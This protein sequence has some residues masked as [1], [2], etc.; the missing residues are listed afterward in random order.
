VGGIFW[1]HP[2]P[3]GTVLGPL[4]FLA[5]INDLP[6]TVQHSSAWLFADNSL[7]RIKDQHDQALIQED[8][9]IL[10]EWEH[11]AN[12][13]Q[14]KQMQCHQC[15]KQTKVQTSSYLLHDQTLETT[16][17]WTSPS[18]VTPLLVHPCW[19]CSSKKKPDSGV[20]VKEHQ[21]MYPKSQVSDI[22]HNGLAHIGIC[23]GCLV[24]A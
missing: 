10:R 4:L 18:A 14:S 11:L 20:P 12:E 16:S 9:D 19:G 3:E 5:Y 15:H 24:E 13:I 23:L 8:F 1:G 17:T 21:G 7:L 22:H 2:V 6:D